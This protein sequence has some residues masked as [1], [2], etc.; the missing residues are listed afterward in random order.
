MIHDGRPVTVANSSESEVSARP[1]AAVRVLR[2]A[3]PSLRAA[4][5]GHAG[6][7]TRRR[8]GPGP[9]HAI[10]MSK[11]ARRNRRRVTGGARA[12]EVTWTVTVTVAGTPRSV[13]AAGGGA[14]APSP[15]QSDSEWAE[16][17]SPLLA[18]PAGPCNRL[19]ATT[20]YLFKL[21]QLESNLAAE[22]R[23]FTAAR[24]R[25]A[26]GRPAEQVQLESAHRPGS[27]TGTGP[28]APGPV[29]RVGESEAHP[30]GVRLVCVRA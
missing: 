17:P 25:Q 22:R 5:P 23:S 28:A 27:G 24:R 13:A 15:S 29:L 9:R 4:G 3:G 21:H 7:P 18:G 16:P 12:A 8:P 14:E 19:G 20:R 30:T 10:M 26:E 2:L 1:A 11:S 6:Q